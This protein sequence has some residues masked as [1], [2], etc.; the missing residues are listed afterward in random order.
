MMSR[1]VQIAH[2]HC[3]RKKLQMIPYKVQILQ[4]LT[5][6]DKKLELCDEIQQSF[7]FENS[8]VADQ[9]VFTDEA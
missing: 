7:D 9:L 3:F 1:E 5:D 6:L 8:N 4:N 2:P